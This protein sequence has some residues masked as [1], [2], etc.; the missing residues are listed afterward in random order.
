MHNV[1]GILVY[2]SI[3]CSISILQNKNVYSADNCHLK[4]AFKIISD[5]IKALMNGFDHRI[6]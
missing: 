1:G 4:I 2:A 5:V 6:F 3:L